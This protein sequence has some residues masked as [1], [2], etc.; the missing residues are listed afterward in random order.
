MA[1]EFSNT[2]YPELHIVSVAGRVRFT[3][4]QFVTD[5]KALGDALCAL[6]DWYGVQLVSAPDEEHEDP[7][8]GGKGSGD[9]S[10]DIKPPARSASKAEWAEYA[11]SRAAD[12]DEV[13]KINLLTKEQ[14][15][16]QYGGDD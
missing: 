1:Y 6:P 7:P 16:E 8:G 11:R 13:D 14:L 5:D 2:K 12:S 3:G 9:G 15:V 4:G 10:K